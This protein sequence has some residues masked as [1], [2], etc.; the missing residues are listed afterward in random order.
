VQAEAQVGTRGEK[1]PSVAHGKAC[2]LSLRD[3]RTCECE[4]GG[5]LHGSAWKAGNADSPPHVRRARSRQ[6]KV[7]RTLAF[8]AAVTVTGTVV[9]LAVTGNFSASSSAGS[10]LSVQLDVDLKDTIA[11]LA[12]LG[13]GGRKIS[14]SSTSGSSDR[15]DCAESTTGLVRQFFTQHPCNQYIAETWTITRQDSNALVAFSWV[16]MAT[17]SLAGKYKG[18]VDASDTGNPPGVSSAF[19]GDCYASDQQGVTVWTVEVKTTGNAQFD[20][21]ILQDA[22]KGDLSEAYLQKHCIK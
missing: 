21:G 20:Q 22:V 14:S 8:T 4:C 6:R 16:E 13:F 10:H 3:P 9:G 15:P 18:T 7:R 19:D 11:T 12:S 17:T 1:E 5:R 2:A